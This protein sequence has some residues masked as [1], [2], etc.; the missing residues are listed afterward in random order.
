MEILLAFS[1]LTEIDDVRK[2]DISSPEFSSCCSPRQF[3][4]SVASHKTLYNWIGP[5]LVFSSISIL[6]LN[7][8]WIVV[9]FLDHRVFPG[10]YSLTVNYVLGSISILVPAIITASSAVYMEQY[11]DLLTPHW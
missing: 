7:F 10:E 9:T 4:A 1:P 5:L 2:S 8:S 6:L 3:L 11:L